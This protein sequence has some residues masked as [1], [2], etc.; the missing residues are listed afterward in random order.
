M[1]HLAQKYPY[2]IRE[3]PCPVTEQVCQESVWLFQNL[4]LGSREDMDDIVEAVA[5]I[6]RAW[7]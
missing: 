4:L 6:Q 5:K 3:L 7:R 2:L 1:A